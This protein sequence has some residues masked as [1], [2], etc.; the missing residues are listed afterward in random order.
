MTKNSVNID[1]VV[2]ESYDIPQSTFDKQRTKTAH[3]LLNTIFP[4]SG[5]ANA[6]YFVNA[7]INDEGYKHQLVR[8]IFILFKTKL[9][10]SKWESI[11]SRLR[12]KPE[13]ITEYFVGVKNNYHL[14]MVV[15]QVP[16]KYAK[17]YIYFKAGKY[18]KFSDE[19]KKTFDRY[20]Y[21]EKMQS[22]ESIIWRVIHKS[23]D[24]RKELQTWIGTESN[25]YTFTDEDEL[26]GIQTP[27]FEHYRHIKPK[28]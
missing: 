23:P 27:E 14:L 11:F 3:F 13:Y 21:D 20:L 2:N 26:W 8:P 18:S 22:V 24:L 6:E 19:Y 7:F 25:D 17:E 16:L 4:K 28:K 10:D 15:F 12:A 9:N 5:I 1:E